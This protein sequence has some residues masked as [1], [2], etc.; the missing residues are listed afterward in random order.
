MMRADDPDERRVD[1]Q[2]MRVHRRVRYRH[3]R[4]Q[5]IDGLV[6]QA[7]VQLGK[8]N[9]AAREMS[10]GKAAM[11]VMS[12]LRQAY[13]GQGRPPPAGTP[14]LPVYRDGPCLAAWRAASAWASKARPPR[15]ISGPRRLPAEPPQGRA[16]ERRLR[17]AVPDAEFASSG[18]ATSHAPSPRPSRNDLPPRE[19][20]N[21]RQ[22][23]ASSIANS[24]MTTRPLSSRRTIVGLGQ[25][26]T[27]CI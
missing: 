1:V 10:L 9:V 20:G 22:T 4:P 26:Q 12:D 18:P 17:A 25:L 23:K 6:I 5:H 16:G 27:G 21:S 13:P 15:Q 24:A 7:L 8:R 19:P 3:V 2:R 14:I 11:Q